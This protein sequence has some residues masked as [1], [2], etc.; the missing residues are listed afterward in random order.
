MNLNFF[1]LFPALWLYFLPTPWAW[2]PPPWVPSWVTVSN[3]WLLALG[4]ACT[5]SQ[6]RED[7]T[8]R[9]RTLF[10]TSYPWWLCRS[11]YHFLFC[12]AGWISKKPKASKALKTL[13]PCHL[14]S[15]FLWYDCSLV[16]S[17]VLECLKTMA[18]SFSHL[19]SV[20]F[21]SSR[22]KTPQLCAFLTPILHS[23]EI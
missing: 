22:M 20:K 13:Y 15:C 5:S 6:A 14:N 12:F 18:L 1:L 8:G 4:R 21:W 10:P 23:S 7:I 9:N 17:F 3:S 19:F 16:L 11:G 2:L